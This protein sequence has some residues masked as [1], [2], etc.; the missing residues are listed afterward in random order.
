M[1]KAFKFSDD[2]NTDLILS[3]NYMVSSNEQELAS[4]LMES[5]DSEFINKVNAGDFIVAGANF[6]CGSSREHAPIA[7]KGAKIAAV[8]AKSYARIFYRNAFNVGLAIYE[9]KPEDIDNIDEGDEIELQNEEGKVLNLSKNKS[10]TITAI[11]K[12]M[13]EL[14]AAGG[15]MAYAKKELEFG[16]KNE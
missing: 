5:Y 1:A 2:I 3:A 4:H 7:I 15:L 8:L 14:I 12:F 9:L 10:Y 13:Q 16:F 11:P 6:G